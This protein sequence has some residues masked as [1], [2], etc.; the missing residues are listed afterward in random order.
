ML[1]QIA[2]ELTG[3]VNAAFEKRKPQ[4]REAPGDAAKED[5]FGGR[6]ADVS[7]SPRPR[8]T[9]ALMLLQ[10]KLRLN[11]AIVRTM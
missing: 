2:E 10:K 7:R 4:F 1:D 8:R 5:R 6:V 3:S 9:W 11:T